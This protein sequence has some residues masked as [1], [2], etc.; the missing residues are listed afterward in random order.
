MNGINAKTLAIVIGCL[1]I[2]YSLF[3]FGINQVRIVAAV[4]NGVL[5]SFA[6]G[7]A[8]LAVVLFLYGLCESPAESRYLILKNPVP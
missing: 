5:I 1:D 4:V 3:I 8:V 6:V 2:L 7:F